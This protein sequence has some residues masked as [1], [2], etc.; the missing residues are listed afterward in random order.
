M[1]EWLIVVAGSPTSGFQGGAR[2]ERGRLGCFPAG[3]EG[4]HQVTGPGTVLI[5]ADNCVPKLVWYP[6]SGEGLGADPVGSAS[7]WRMLF[8]LQWKT[9]NEGA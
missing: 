8:D 1:E 3:P 2:A 5:L 4:G 9:E 7:A 6:H